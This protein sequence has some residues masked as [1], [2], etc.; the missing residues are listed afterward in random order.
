MALFVSTNINGSRAESALIEFSIGSFGKKYQAKLEI[1][2]SPLNDKLIQTIFYNPNLKF[3]KKFSPRI[4]KSAYTKIGDETIHFVYQGLD[5]LAERKFF[6]QAT[7]FKSDSTL[8]SKSLYEKINSNEISFY[9][10][11]IEYKVSSLKIVDEKGLFLIEDIETSRRRLKESEYSFLLLDYDIQTEQNLLLISEL[12]KDNLNISLET[13]DEIKARSANALKSLHL[14]LLIISLISILIA[15]FMVANTMSGIF[16]SRKKELGIFRCLGISRIENLILF[17]SQT[18]LL[19]LAGTFFG[20][21]IGIF[22]SRFNNFS[23]ES[24]VV[25]MTQA[26]AYT[27]FSP[28][29]F[30]ISIIIGLLGSVFSGIFP[31]IQSFK[32]QAISLVRE[33]RQNNK[34]QY[35]KHFFLLGCILIFVS[36]ALSNLKSPIELPIYGFLSIGFIIVALVF[37]FPFLMETILFILNKVLNLSNQSFISLRIGL[38]EIVHYSI[39][40]SLTSA[41]LMLGVSLIICLSTL[42]ESYEKS[43]LDWTE[44]EFPFEYSIVN[45]SDIDSGTNFGIDKNLKSK[46][47]SLKHLKDIDVLLLNTKIKFGSKTFTVHGYD[48]QLAKL[49]EKQKM[50]SSYPEQINENEILISSNMAYLNGYKIND[51]LE[52]ETNSG[53]TKFKVIGIREHFFSETGTIMMDYRDFEKNFKAENYKS[54]RFNTRNQAGKLDLIEVQRLIDFDKNLQIINSEELKEIYI[55]GVRKVFKSLNSLK[56][57]AFF[58]S[59]ISLLSSVFYNLL[60]KLKSL[61]ALNSIGASY[62]QLMKIIFF[63]NLFLTGFGCLN[64]ILLSF[65]LNPII[66]EVI[67][68]S[69]FG[70]TMI[71]SEN[72]GLILLCLAFIPIFSCISIIYPSILLKKLSLQKILSFE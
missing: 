70:W 65:L 26:I 39:K 3:I 21:G 49:L 67:N 68:K 56:Y 61:A 59:L 32:I 69:A 55:S 19:G 16:I 27:E 6:K 34:F 7:E 52:L 58:I 42:T 22:I 18:F 28:R 9:I 47:E 25:D 30:L 31:A 23:G 45:R 4:K 29:L 64:G 51:E 33:T 38:E 15:F 43:I 48:L 53:K 60:D 37:T 13:I 12:K 24:T 63:E 40:N 1:Q 62:F 36:L 5:F 71:Q 11:Q 72:S 20:I 35:S 44:R 17:F 50:L 46:I 14:N 10:N 8:I 66:L 57:S 2:N 41:T 54:I